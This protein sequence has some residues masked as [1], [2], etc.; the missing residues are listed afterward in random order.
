MATLGFEAPSGPLAVVRGLGWVVRGTET[1]HK[2]P[3]RK[4]SGYRQAGLRLPRGGQCN[5]H[6]LAFLPR[7]GGKQEGGPGEGSQDGLGHLE[8]EAFGNQVYV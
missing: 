5:R 1:M 8:F 7:T 4:G 2:K 6:P 3:S